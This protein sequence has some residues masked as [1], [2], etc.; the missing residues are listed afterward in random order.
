MEHSL[1]LTEDDIGFDI[2]VCACGWTGP[3]VP[4]Q[5]IAGDSF[6]QHVASFVEAERDRLREALEEILATAKDPDI[7]LSGRV[8]KIRGKAHLALSGGRGE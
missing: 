4:D 8:T 7:S 3:P 6:A 2:A 5:E 1:T